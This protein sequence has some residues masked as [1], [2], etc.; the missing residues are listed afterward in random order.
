MEHPY[1]SSEGDSD[2]PTVPRRRRDHRA[3]RVPPDADFTS[4][5]VSVS[6]E[7][8]RRTRPAQ[9]GRRF[10]EST[11]RIKAVLAGLSIVVG[12]LF[13]VQPRDWIEISSDSNRMLAAACWS[14]GSCSCRSRPGLCLPP[15]STPRCEP[16]NR[17]ECR[18]RRGGVAVAVGPPTKKFT[19]LLDDVEVKGT[20]V[21][22]CSFCAERDGGPKADGEPVGN[23]DHMDVAPDSNYQHLVAFAPLGPHS[24]FLHC[25]TYPLN[26]ADD[27]IINRADG[28]LLPI[29]PDADVYRARD[30]ATGVSRDVKVGN[31]IRMVGRWV[32]EN[33]IRGS[34]R[35]SSAAGYGWVRCSPSCT[36]TYGPTSAVARPHANRADRRDDLRGR[37]ALRGGLL[38]WGIARARR[39]G[40]HRA[41]G[42]IGRC[43]GEN[44]YR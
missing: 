1:G 21:G 34:V 8:R 38:P 32:L 7:R 17:P 6:A 3:V 43:R 12:L 37:S 20:V 27:R 29:K 16:V 23:L 33:G 24:P 9:L 4:T 19:W 39:A 31:R 35:P 13:A 10:V 42:G 36:R 28:W 15:T 40:L 44:F 2:G 14:W 11:T 22:T 25:E 30:P 18:L 5:T 26:V 41:P